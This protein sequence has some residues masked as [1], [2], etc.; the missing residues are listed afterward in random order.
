MIV[1]VEQRCPAVVHLHILTPSL[2]WTQMEGNVVLKSF[3]VNVEITVLIMCWCAENVLPATRIVHVHESLALPSG[4]LPGIQP[5]KQHLFKI[6]WKRFSHQFSIF[7]DLVIFPNSKSDPVSNE[8]PYL[9]DWSISVA[10][11]S[12]AW[13]SPK[14]TRSGNSSQVK[15]Y[16]CI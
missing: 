7:L 10:I 11:S 9:S 8:S 15:V 1:F 6:C 3:K 16:F 12:S 5:I 4:K 14:I 2:V 13:I